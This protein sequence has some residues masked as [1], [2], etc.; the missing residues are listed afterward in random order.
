M[1]SCVQWYLSWQSTSLLT[2]TIRAV[3]TIG[4][5]CPVVPELA[6]N[7]LVYVNDQS[8]P[9][10]LAPT[11][12][13]SLDEG[14]AACSTTLGKRSPRLQ[15]SSFSIISSECVAPLSSSNVSVDRDIDKLHAGNHELYLPPRSSQALFL[16]KSS[17]SLYVHEL[18]ARNHELYTGGQSCW[19]TLGVECYGMF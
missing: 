17:V 2:L 10:G 15:F 16:R 1:D 9:Y 13:F 5:V 14:P 3:L 18:H 11:L 7:L 4:F 12:L 19:S 6:V 8:R